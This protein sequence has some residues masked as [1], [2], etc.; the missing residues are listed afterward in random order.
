MGEDEIAPGGVYDHGTR[1]E[2]DPVTWEAHVSPRET[3]GAT[4]TR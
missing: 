2:D 4:E 3:T 1:E